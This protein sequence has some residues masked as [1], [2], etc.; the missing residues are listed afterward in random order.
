M[1]Y[2]ISRPCRG[3][4]YGFKMPRI[5]TCI[6]HISAMFDVVFFS[7]GE[8]LTWNHGGHQGFKKKKKNTPV[9]ASAASQDRLKIGIMSP[10]VMSIISWNV[11]PLI[12]WFSKMLKSSFLLLFRLVFRSCAVLKPQFNLW[13]HRS[14]YS[15][16]KMKTTEIVRSEEPNLESLI[17]LAIFCI[18][19][20]IY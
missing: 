20:L 16:W 15:D 9:E 19:H 12:P 11:L 4:Q 14:C 7:H 17:L 5:L 6:P 8:V 1:G 13:L 18:L 2:D 3:I 10:C